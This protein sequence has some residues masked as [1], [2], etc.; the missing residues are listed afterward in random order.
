MQANVVHL[1]QPPVLA[2][3]QQINRYWDQRM[4]VCAV[5]ILPGKL[6]VSL[7]GEMVSTVL[8]S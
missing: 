8:G 1:Q 6:Y 7:H 3:F 5:K 2:G 4:S